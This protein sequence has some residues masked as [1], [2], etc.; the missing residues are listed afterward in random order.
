MNKNTI[1]TEDFARVGSAA[2]EDIL[3]AGAQRLLQLALEAEI[4]DFIDQYRSLRNDNGKQLVVRNGYQPERTIM[5][6]V[7]SITVK[8]PRIDDRCLALLQKDR[9]ESLVLP[10]FVRRTPSINNL[11]PMLYLQGVSSERFPE[12]LQAILGEGAKN[13]SSNTIMR[14]KDAW[15]KEYDD[16][17]NRDL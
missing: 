16:W 10:K 12:A 1:T 17:I 15:C 9:F 4:E 2:L 14:L 7:G 8:R 6:G 3:K 5:T 11:L 13:I